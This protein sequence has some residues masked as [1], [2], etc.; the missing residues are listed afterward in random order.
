MTSPACFLIG[1]EMVVIKKSPGTVWFRGMNIQRLALAELQGL[2]AT[3][4]QTSGNFFAF[5]LIFGL[6][7]RFFCTLDSNFYPRA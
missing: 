4:C 3:P 6:I 1:E 5:Y 2:G 7:L